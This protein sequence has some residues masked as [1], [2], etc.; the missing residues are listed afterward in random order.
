[1]RLRQ[2]SSGLILVVENNA[3]T[4]TIA[5]VILQSANFRVIEARDVHEALGS[6]CFFSDIQVVFMGCS[7]PVSNDDIS[8]VRSV[9]KLSPAIKI[10]M[11]S[12]DMC[13][14]TNSL[15]LGVSFIAQPY[16]QSVL[17]HDIQS[18]LGDRTTGS[19]APQRRDK[20]VLTSR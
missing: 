20:R 1:M 8:F 19:M 7:M 5:V 14:D 12:A 6:L 15:P 17:I 16:R 4:R 3:H 10:L 9:Q 13:P 2:K 18:L 11:T